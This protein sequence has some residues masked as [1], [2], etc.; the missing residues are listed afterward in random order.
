MN[1]WQVGILALLER[2]P[3]SEWLQ[4]PNIAKTL[5]GDSNAGWHSDEVKPIRFALKELEQEGRIIYRSHYGWHLIEG[6]KCGECNQPHWFHCE[7]AKRQREEDG[8]EWVKVG[9]K[10]YNALPHTY[11]REGYERLPRS[12]SRF[13]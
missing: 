3:Q 6:L 9:E 1:K 8:L 11:E 2:S 7:G 4:G 13:S 5:L 12:Q 10:W